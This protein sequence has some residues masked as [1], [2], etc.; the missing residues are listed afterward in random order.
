MPP[1][2]LEVELLEEIFM[3]IQAGTKQDLRYLVTNLLISQNHNTEFLYLM[4]VNMVL[5]L[6]TKPLVFLFLKQVN[7]LGHKQIK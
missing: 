5:L 3:K 6:E 2:K 4:I 7:F 1:L